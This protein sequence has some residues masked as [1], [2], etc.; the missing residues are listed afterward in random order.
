V[1][2]FIR[3]QVIQA[4]RTLLPKHF[5]G[6]WHTLAWCWAGSPTSGVARSTG[7]FVASGRGKFRLD[8]EMHNLVFGPRNT[9]MAARHGRTFA[10]EN[11]GFRIHK[12]CRSNLFE[13]PAAEK[14]LRRRDHHDAQAWRPCRP[15]ILAAIAEVFD[16]ALVQEP[17]QKTNDETWAA[18]DF[19]DAALSGSLA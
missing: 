5:F 6:R 11:N 13:G 3:V 2:E 9:H 16:A 15:D 8:E 14:F 7:I 10:A 1:H 19:G 4:V 12:R 18:R 17:R